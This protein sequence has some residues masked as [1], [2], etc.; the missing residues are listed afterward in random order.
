MKTNADIRPL[1]EEEI[2]VVKTFVPA[3]WHFDLG[4]FMHSNFHEPFF[5]AFAC[6][7]KGQVT[8]TGNVIVNGEVGWLGNIIIEPS[9]RSNGLGFQLTRYLVEYLKTQGCKSQI[10]IATEAGKPMYQK[11]GF[12]TTSVYCFLKGG[13][14]PVAPDMS[15]IRPII[16]ED[17]PAL[18]QLDKTASGEDR[19]HLVEKNLNNAWIYT[20]DKNNIPEGFYL[21]SFGN[22]LIVASNPQAGLKLLHLK[23]YRYDQVAVLPCDNKI[24]TEFLKHFHFKEY[25][26]SPRMVLGEEVEWRPEMIFSRA[27][28]YCG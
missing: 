25:L 9:H 7:D 17:I 3:E 12:L 5:K 2:E 10:L 13:R 21:P 24:A 1:K 19:F 16:P 18:R 28:G 22:G 11:L 8:G 6:Y 14:I 26:L 27:A 4:Q 20:S 15:Y 23:H